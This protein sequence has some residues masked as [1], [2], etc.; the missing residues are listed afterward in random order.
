MRPPDGARVRRATTRNSVV[1]S[2]SGRPRMVRRCGRVPRGRVVVMGPLPRMFALAD[3]TRPDASTTCTIVSSSPGAEGVVGRLPWRADAARSSARAWVARSTLSTS[4]RRR[5]TRT[6]SALIASASAT[7]RHAATV[8]RARIVP[9]RL[10]NRL[11]AVRVEA[12]ADEP[13]GLDR[14][15]IE[16]QVDLLAQVADV[17]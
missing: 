7:T 2:G 13:D 11:T 4:E 6:R 8:V 12:V 14:L 16:R 17:D 9:T 1:S 3:T 5:T 15:A 10:N